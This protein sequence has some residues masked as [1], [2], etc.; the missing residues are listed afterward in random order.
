MSARSILPSYLKRHQQNRATSTSKRS[1]RIV[2]WDRDIVCLPKENYKCQTIPYPRGKYRSRLA[3]QGLIGKIHLTSEMS[4]EDVKAEVCSVFHKAMNE[5]SDF[6]F[7]FLQPTGGGTQSLTIPSVSSSFTW[8]A[9]QVARLGNN[10]GTIFIMA[11]EDLQLEVIP[12][13]HIFVMFFHC[14]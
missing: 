9:Q 8:N 14:C 12:K 5:K 1:K 7:V 4:I 2:T 3:A 10:K 13:L 6:S 11:Q